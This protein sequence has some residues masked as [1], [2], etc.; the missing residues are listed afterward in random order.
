MTYAFLVTAQAGDGQIEQI[1]RTFGVDWT[2]LGAQDH[3]LR[4]DVRGAL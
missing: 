3:Q 2:H 4:R 1:A